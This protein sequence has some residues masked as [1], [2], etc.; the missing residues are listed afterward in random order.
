MSTTWLGWFELFN[1]NS[2][3]G[4]K[5]AS[6]GFAHELYVG[7]KHNSTRCRA[8]QSRILIPLCADRLSRI[9]W[10]QSPSGLAAR[11]V[12]NAARTLPADFC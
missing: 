2:R 12:F 1:T 9:T 7:V 11:I 4:P 5:C 10:I 8:A 3:N 6:I